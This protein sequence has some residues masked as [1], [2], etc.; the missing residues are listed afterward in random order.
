MLRSR[1][2]NNFGFGCSCQRNFVAINLSFCDGVVYH[3]AVFALNCRIRHGMSIK[4]TRRCHANDISVLK[5]LKVL[6][7]FNVLQTLGTRFKLFLKLRDCAAVTFTNVLIP[8][9]IQTPAF[10]DTQPPHI[11]DL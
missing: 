6:H 4:L 2:P 9:S 3:C 10:S 5:N 8:P 7:I 1:S 11:P